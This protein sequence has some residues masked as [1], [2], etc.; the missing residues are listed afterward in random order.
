M[1]IFLLA[2]LSNKQI[3][4][5]YILPIYPFLY[6]I[7]S[8]I[9]Y[10]DSPRSG[11]LPFR[12]LIVGLLLWYGYSSLKIHPHYLAYFNE[13]VGGPDSGWKYLVDSNLDWGQDLKGLSEYLKK[14][15]NP[16]ITLS[17]FGT[18]D[19]SAYGIRYQAL[20][21]IS[22]P[23]RKGQIDPSA[24]MRDILAISATNLQGVYYYQHDFFH[25]LKDLPI[26][27]KIG[28]TIF[29][30]DIKNTKNRK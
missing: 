9:V 26:K 24:P 16:E 6:V 2:S 1:F 5:R 13:L 21:I 20:G 12:I 11:T 22:L 29:V 19:P 30:Y 25:W 10:V 15:G 23:E 4:L 7:V 28:Y 3:G 8:K 17:Y 14:E 27:K 18:A